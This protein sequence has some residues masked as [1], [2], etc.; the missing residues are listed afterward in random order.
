VN[1]Q[2]FIV[3]GCEVTGTCAETMKKQL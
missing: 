3:F 1:G 2:G